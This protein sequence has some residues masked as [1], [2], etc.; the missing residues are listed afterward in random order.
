MKPFDPSPS[1]CKVS[2][3]QTKYHLLW[4]D[5]S[6]LTF[7]FKELSS[8]REFANLTI[9]LCICLDAR[10]VFSFWNDVGNVTSHCCIKKIFD[11]GMISKVEQNKNICENVFSF[12]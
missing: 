11:Y 5:K 7:C 4:L 1:S 9:D 8:L 12:H 2:A 3:W 10:I 6:W